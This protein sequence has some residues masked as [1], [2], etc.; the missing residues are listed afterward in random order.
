MVALMAHSSAKNGPP[1]AHEK[2]K[3]WIVIGIVVSIALHQAAY[4]NEENAFQV[5][6]KT[7]KVFETWDYLKDFQ[8]LNNIICQDHRTFSYLCH[9]VGELNIVIECILYL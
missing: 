3:E 8:E 2:H 1:K 4:G 6:M 5:E 7:S 9:P